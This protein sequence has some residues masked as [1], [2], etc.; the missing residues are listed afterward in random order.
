MSDRIPANGL[1]EEIS[2]QDPIYT[3]KLFDF[4]S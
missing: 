1:S 4:L 2:H 3:H